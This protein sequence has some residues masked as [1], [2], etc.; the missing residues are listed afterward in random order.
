ME[1]ITKGVEAK[2]MPAFGA[3]LTKLQQR[4]VLAYVRDAFGTGAEGTNRAR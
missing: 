1:S 2:G 3:S 4:A